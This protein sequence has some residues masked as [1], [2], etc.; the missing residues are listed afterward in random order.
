MLARRVIAPGGITL[1]S[2]GLGKTFFQPYLNIQQGV[3]GAEAALV[4]YLT[5]LD[6]LLHQR[7][8]GVCFIFVKRFFFGEACV[9]TA[10]APTVRGFY[11]RCAQWCGIT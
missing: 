9:D 3:F 6:Q 1:V 10:S 5:R 8:V 4:L 7:P 2:L 11:V